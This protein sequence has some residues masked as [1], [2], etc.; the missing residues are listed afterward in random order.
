MSHLILLYSEHVSKN[1]EAPHY[2]VFSI[3]LVTSPL[4][5][6]NNLLSTL[7][8]PPPPCAQSLTRYEFQWYTTQKLKPTST[9]SKHRTSR[10][11]RRPAIPKLDVFLFF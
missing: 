8:F 9:G 11:E 5:R 10:S 6:Q 1:D 2:T 4:F 3:P 7:F